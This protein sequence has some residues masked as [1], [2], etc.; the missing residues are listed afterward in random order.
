MA[1]RVIAFPG[2]IVDRPGPRRASA[3]EMARSRYLD[4]LEQQARGGDVG[5]VAELKLA[6]IR[7]LA[8]LACDSRVLLP[9]CHGAIAAVRKLRRQLEGL[10]RS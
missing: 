8:A 7:D 2:V 5:A 6:E 9:R 10:G 3:A 4:R 1:G